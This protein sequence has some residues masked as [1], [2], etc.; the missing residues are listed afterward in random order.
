MKYDPSKENRVVKAIMDKN[1]R[2]DKIQVSTVTREGSDFV[3]ADI[4]LMYT[5]EGET[6]LR[7]TPKGLRFSAKL[8]PQLAKVLQDLADELAES[9]NAE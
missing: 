2:G 8:V 4:R 3:W 5:P 7:P 9:E 1:D 6:E